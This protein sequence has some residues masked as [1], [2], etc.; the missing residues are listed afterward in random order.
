MIVKGYFKH[1]DNFLILMSS[2]L[3]VYM[4]I[5][6]GLLF[7]NFHVSIVKFDDF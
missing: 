5:H 7:I 1:P 2:G 3:K 6:E 4:Y